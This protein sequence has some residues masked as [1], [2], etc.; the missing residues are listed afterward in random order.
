MLGAPSPFAVTA[1]STDAS[2][3]LKSKRLGEKLHM[4]CAVTA[5]SFSNSVMR[6]SGQATFDDYIIYGVR[7]LKSSASRGGVNVSV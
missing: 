4:V 3:N 1:G 6:I 5:V 2:S 7:L